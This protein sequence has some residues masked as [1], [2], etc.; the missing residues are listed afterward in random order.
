LT[1]PESR[2]NYTGKTIQLAVAILRS[3]NP[4]RGPDPV[5]FLAGGPG[6]G[7]L[8][9]AALVAAGYAPT[10]AQRDIILIDQRGTGFSQPN[11]SCAQPMQTSGKRLP[12]GAATND[13]PAFIQAQVDDLITCGN[14]LRA[15]GIDLRAYNSAENSADLEDLRRALGYGPWN[16]VGV[17]YGSRLALTAMRYRPETIRSMVLDSAVP[18]Q[19]NF[20]V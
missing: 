6:Q 18:L 9:L 4:Q 12:F 14:R 13:R 3:P 8:P 2:S 7:T 1:V 17:S 5:V 15:A 11:L 19:S 16:L 20:M 10:L